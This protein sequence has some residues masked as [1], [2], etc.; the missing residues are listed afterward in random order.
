MTGKE[1]FI[2]RI[3]PVRKEMLSKGYTPE[4]ERTILKHRDYIDGLTRR[5]IVK[6]AGRTR[7]TGPE[8]F[9][10]VILESENLETARGLMNED[11][12][13]SEGVMLAE[14]FPF[15]VAFERN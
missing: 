6:L 9:G 2:Y 1:Q 5:G 4:E 15:H 10:I 11:P 3:Q 13:V 8:S 12:A 14:L 7:T